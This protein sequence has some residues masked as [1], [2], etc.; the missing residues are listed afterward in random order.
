MCLKF[1]L[2]F[3]GFFFYFFFCKR[4]TAYEV[5]ISDWSSDVCSSDLLETVRG[6]RAQ[7]RASRVRNNVPTA[8]IVGYTNAGKS[9]LFNAMT[10]DATFASSQLFATLDT[11]VRKLPLESG[12]TVLLADTVGFIRDQIGR[13]T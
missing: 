8:S 6:R 1:V 5:P 3:I 11:T 13:A 9:T 2:E 4:K 12:D 7:N 10:G